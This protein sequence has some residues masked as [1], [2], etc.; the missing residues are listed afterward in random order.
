MLKATLLMKM[1]GMLT[2]QVTEE[3]KKRITSAFTA[4]EGALDKKWTF[5]MSREKG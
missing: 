5:P 1:E 2:A 3:L 4:S